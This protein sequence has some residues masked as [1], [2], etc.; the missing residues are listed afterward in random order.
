MVNKVVKLAIIAG[1]IGYLAKRIWEHY[2]RSDP[3]KPRSSDGSSDPTAP[4]AEPEPQP[5]ELPQWSLAKLKEC[6]G[7]NGNPKCVSL[8]GIVY[9]VS[10]NDDGAYD[11]PSEY[12]SFLGHDCTYAYAH[13]ST[14]ATD[15]DKDARD[16]MDSQFLQGFIEHYEH[17][18]H[19]PKVATLIDPPCNGV[20]VPEEQSISTPGSNEVGGRR[21][22]VIAGG[23]A[24]PSPEP[25][26]DSSWAQEWEEGFVDP[27]TLMTDSM[28][29]ISSQNSTPI[30]SPTKDEA[31]DATASTTVDTNRATRTVGPK[32]PE[33]G[34]FVGDY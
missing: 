30:T 24:S 8:K 1:V 19:Y 31:P 21:L 34:Y 26:L 11:P 16:C 20:S 15:L 9:D 33:G 27:A 2:Q 23:Q 18:K 29:E 25:N 12:H 14:D 7:L 6:T 17:I 5:E 13:Y 3:N 4:V 28:V 10:S 32:T 22:Q